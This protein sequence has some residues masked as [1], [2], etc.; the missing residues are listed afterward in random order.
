MNDFI[1]FV[2]NVFNRCTYFMY[3]RIQMHIVIIP[4]PIAKYKM[5]NIDFS[6]KF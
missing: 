5:K 1:L 3:K 2:K 6:M 4:T